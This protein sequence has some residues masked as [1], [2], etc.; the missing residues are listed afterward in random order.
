MD[1]RTVHS[2][3]ILINHDGNFCFEIARRG[4]GG[5]NCGL[6]DYVARDIPHAYDKAV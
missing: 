1:T 2:R 6:R 3:A 4:T 5:L